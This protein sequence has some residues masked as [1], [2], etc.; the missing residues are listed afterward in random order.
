MDAKTLFDRLRQFTF[1]RL[2]FVN[3]KLFNNIRWGW[4][5]EYSAEQIT[6]LIHEWDSIMSQTPRSDTN[7]SAKPTF[8]SGSNYAIL[9]RLC[10]Q[11][12]IYEGSANLQKKIIAEVEEIINELR[13]DDKAQKDFEAM[14]NATQDD[15]MSRFR[16]T[17]PHLKEKDYK[18]YSYLVA[19]FSATTISVLFGVEKSV[20][21]NRISRLKRAI[22]P[23]DIPQ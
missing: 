19:G 21:Y 14:L 2:R 16:S 13:N 1:T 12:Y 4:Y 20:V 10:E 7:D 6:T 18:L 23:D 22:N 17:Y 9:T 15:V 11:Y 5:R 8:K 3:I